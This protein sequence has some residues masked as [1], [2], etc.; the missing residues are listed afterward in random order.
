[1]Y[2]FITAYK[3]ITSS[4]MFSALA[5]QHPFLFYNTGTIGVP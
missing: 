3:I 4:C 1:M 2:E 5:Q